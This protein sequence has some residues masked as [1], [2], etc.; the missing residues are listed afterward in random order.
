MACPAGT[1]GSSAGASD[2]TAC[3]PCP[4]GSYCYAGTIDPKRSKCFGGFACL[5]GA[6]GESC[7]DCEAQFMPLRTVRTR[8]HNW[9]L[10]DRPP[11]A[12]RTRRTS[13]N[14]ALGETDRR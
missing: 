4:I 2:V 9:S 12:Q 3:L 6:K 5:G 14:R 7:A 13:V 11:I 8:D 1:F 10:D